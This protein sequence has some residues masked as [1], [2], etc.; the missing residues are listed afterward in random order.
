MIIPDAAVGSIVAAAIAGLVVF[1]STVLT[2]EQKTSEFRQVWIDE[3]RKDIAQFVAGVSEVVTLHKFKS[4]GSEEDYI[5]FLDDN[6]EIIHELQ[7]VEHRI[8][9][10]LNPNEH[11]AL[12]SQV[13]AFRKEMLRAY[14][15]K[16]RAEREEQLTK[17]L[18]DTIKAVLAFEWHRVKT[19]E[20]MFRRVK[21]AAFIALVCLLLSLVVALFVNQSKGKADEKASQE[22]SQLPQNFVVSESSGTCQRIILRC[23]NNLP[24]VATPAVKMCVPKSQCV[25]E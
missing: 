2:K 17:E 10:R 23:N 7:T 24:I 6:F 20:P 14:Q 15:H 3:L 11:Q 5:K 1:I 16:D 12:I 9:L 19:G 25:S 4:I 18:L 21:W 8:V 13:R 22:T